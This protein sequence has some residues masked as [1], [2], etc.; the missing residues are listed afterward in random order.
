MIPPREQIINQIPI[1]Y[2]PIG[3]L[4]IPAFVGLLVI[5]GSLLLISHFSWWM[6][7]LAVLVLFISFGLEWFMHRDILHKPWKYLEPINYKHVMHHFIYTDEDMTLKS[8][9]EWHLILMPA[10]AIVAVLA[11]I[12]PSIGLFWVIF[13]KDIAL[14]I[15]STMVGFYLSYEWLHLSY[16]LPADSW[17]GQ[18]KAIKYLRKH[19]QIHHKPENMRDFNFNVTVPVFD[20]IMGTNRKENK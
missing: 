6:L 16:H 17:F 20:W 13:G 4:L 19:H 14:V 10:Y 18:T 12:L 1:S 8:S 2:N 9:R 3:H 7:G 15:L 5:I 11:F